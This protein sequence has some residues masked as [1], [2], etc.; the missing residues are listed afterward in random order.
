MA[1][2]TLICKVEKSMLEANT[3]ETPGHVGN[4]R[5]LKP[6]TAISQALRG[7]T[8]KKEVVFS[9]PM[10]GVVVAYKAI[11]SPS[12]A[13]MID[14]LR[15]SAAKRAS[16]EV[17][18]YLYKVWIPGLAGTTYNLL[19]CDDWKDKDKF[20][21]FMTMAPWVP[22]DIGA[23]QVQGAIP[24][25]TQVKVFFGNTHT[26]ADPKIIEIGENIPGLVTPAMQ[27][28]P[29]TKQAFKLGTSAAPNS[30]RG[31]SSD[32]SSGGIDTPAP[33]NSN[34]RADDTGPIKGK[35]VYARGTRNANLKII[36][37]YMT[38][39]GLTNRYMKIALLSV[40][41]KESAL[42]PQEE[43]GYGNASVRR[44]REIFGSRVKDFNDTELK[45]LAADDKKFF[46]HI[47]GG[48][49]KNFEKY[50]NRPGTSDGYDYRGR[51]MNQITFRGSYKN[52][53]DRIGVDFVGS[54]DL[55]NNPEHASHAAVNFLVR[56]LKMSASPV[57][58]DIN[59]ATTQEEANIV[60]ARANAGWGKTGP[61]V[62]RAI[63]STNKASYKFE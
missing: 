2:D 1:E 48:H 32:N 27:Q 61:A 39:Y 53:G 18:N 37:R 11:T 40:I 21:Y 12:P 43:K 31:S 36:E 59:S 13:Y 8:F 55:M 15:Y 52:S 50:G 38:Q 45:A 5:T 41:A 24:P 6:S 19:E 16:F 54:P 62:D 26:L 35:G 25:G 14:R 20:N 22:V 58:G 10:E 34:V 46:N 4:P 49:F 47:Y 51:G 56:R 17:F 60:V 23:N 3:V 7:E 30:S 28:P 44:I 42:M 63:N 33:N 29:S 57:S 9:N